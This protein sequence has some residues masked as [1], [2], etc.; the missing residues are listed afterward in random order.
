MLRNGPCM[1]TLVLCA[2]AHSSKTWAGDAPPPADTLL[3]GKTL[4]PA[5]PAPVLSFSTNPFALDASMDALRPAGVMAAPVN[6]FSATEFK[7]RK[8]SSG[9]QAMTDYGSGD[10]MFR[11]T[12]VWQ[13]LDEFRAQ[14]R[15]RV[16][17]LLEMGGTNL[18]LQ[19]GRKG[20]P[21]LQWSSSWT[22]RSKVSSGLLDGFLAASLSGMTN[23]N[24]ASSHFTPVPATQTSPLIPTAIPAAK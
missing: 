18:S 8:R 9:K 12:T 17:T 21:S 2:L 3:N 7:P 23:R 24:H 13:R 1:L 6:D 10:P 14:D 19:A 5:A 16:L 22:K 4:R 15:V 11:T 20:D